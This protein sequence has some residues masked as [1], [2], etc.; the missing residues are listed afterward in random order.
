MSI[1][2]PARLAAVPTVIVS[3]P[4][5]MLPAYTVDQGSRVNGEYIRFG[6][7]LSITTG[8]PRR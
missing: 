4:A 1:L 3:F 6:I 2:T 7:Q 8:G 5:F